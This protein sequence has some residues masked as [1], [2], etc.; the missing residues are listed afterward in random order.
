MIDLVHRG[1]V[2]VDAEDDRVFEHPPGREFL[3]ELGRRPE[4]V[5]DAVAI[6]RPRRAPWWR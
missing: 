6:T 1:A 2:H 3:G 4:V 5:I